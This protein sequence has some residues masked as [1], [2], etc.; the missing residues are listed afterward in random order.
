M[1]GLAF[2][3]RIDDKAAKSFDVRSDTGIM[4]RIAI[5]ICLFFVASSGS[6]ANAEHTL[7]FDTGPQT[8]IST[9]DQDF[10]ADASPAR[11]HFKRSSRV[12]SSPKSLPTV[13]R[14]HPR[15]W[16]RTTQRPALREISPMGWMNEA[17]FA[18][19]VSKSSVFQQINV[20]RI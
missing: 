4:K 16:A 3:K 9:D 15:S 14:P 5:V 2:R 10:S 20:Y 8:G 1:G 11:R 6:F 18:P 17:V 13:K 12:K 19:R 7:D